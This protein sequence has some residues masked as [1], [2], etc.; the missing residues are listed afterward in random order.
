MKIIQNLKKKCKIYNKINKN[1][2]KKWNKIKIFLNKNVLKKIVNF[3]KGQQQKQIK[4]KFLIN[5]INS[6]LKMK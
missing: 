2:K 4:C 5:K 3:K 6:N 1:F